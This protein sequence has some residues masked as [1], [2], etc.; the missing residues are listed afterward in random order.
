VA[1]QS[2]S[3]QR[4][5][6]R[7]AGEDVRIAERVGEQR[8]S[9]I[10]S[11]QAYGEV[12][13]VAPTQCLDAQTGVVAAPVPSILPTPAKLLKFGDRVRFAG[14]RREQVKHLDARAE[15]VDT[16][17]DRPRDTNSRRAEFRRGPMPCAPG[18]PGGAWPL[19]PCSVDA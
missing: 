18:V 17:R 11:H 10:G 5:R 15:G 14:A 6:R 3:I 8:A 12:M 9:S 19:P 13:G 16:A 4:L 2:V 1:H 7:F